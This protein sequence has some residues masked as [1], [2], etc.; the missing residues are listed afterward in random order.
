ML[1]GMGLPQL[2]GSGRGDLAVHVKLVVPTKLEK[3]QEQL[4][5]SFAEATGDQVRAEKHGLFGRRKK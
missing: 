5:R 1:R 4:L 2:R 3:E